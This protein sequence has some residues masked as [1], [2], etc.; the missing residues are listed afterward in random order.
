LHNWHIEAIAWRL[1]QCLTG[2]VNR[3]VIT[4]PPRSLKSI[5]ASVAFPAWALGHDPSKRIIC[6]SYSEKLA[7]KHALDSR[8]VMEAE[9]YR[10]VFPFT[11][12]S[13]EKNTELNFVTTRHG[14]R[15]STSVGGTLTG[16]GGNIVI[17]D[18]PIKPEDA[19]SEATR[20]GVNEWFDHTLYSRLD[21]KRQDVIILIM[22][23]LH[24]EDLVGYLLQK[25]PWLHL[26]LPAIAEVEQRIQIGPDESYTRK[27]GEILHE[28]REPRSV[29]ERLRLALGSFNFSAQY[30]QCPVP[31][32]GEIIKWDWFRFY[33]ELPVRA[34]GDRIIQSWDTAS[35]AEE[36]SDYSVGTTWLT[37]GNNYYRHR[38]CA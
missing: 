17:I 15:Y 26:N 13:R 29:L 23:R 8:A 34:A 19:I 28:A 10:R 30:Q 11:R 9:W 18:D 37:E 35:K 36:I 16:R 31:L 21:D 7:S 5:C 38:R 33:D 27:V 2:D 25:E 1:Q 6:A 14:Y 20:S 22:Q 3:L 4:L 24:V 32:E 12:I